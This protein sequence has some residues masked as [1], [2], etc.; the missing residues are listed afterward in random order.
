M[1]SAINPLRSFS[2]NR[3]EFRSFSKED[4]PLLKKVF[5]NDEVMRYALVDAFSEEMLSNYF[6]RILE[7]NRS[8]EKDSYEYAVY[9]HSEFIGFADFTLIIKNSSGGVAEIGYLLLP[10]YW[11][12]GYGTQAAGKLIDICFQD[13]KLHRVIAK[14]NAHNIAS[15]RVMM[16]NGMEKEATLRK[17]RFKAGQWVDEY[18]FA[19][20]RNGT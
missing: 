2:M 10:E 4:Y 7:N 15:Q 12:K 19:L 3:I 20:M 5:Q 18:L 13:L 8:S 11:G 17:Q 16:K 14:C 6:Q 9:H 1:E